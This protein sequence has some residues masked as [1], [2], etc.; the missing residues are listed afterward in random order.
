MGHRK[1]VKNNPDIA[2][3]IEKG[4]SARWVPLFLWPHSFVSEGFS[5]DSFRRSIAA[6]KR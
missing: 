2:V 6:S 3:S 1:R 5:T 4:H